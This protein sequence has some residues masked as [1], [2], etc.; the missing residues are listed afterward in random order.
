MI[1]IDEMAFAGI[2]LITTLTMATSVLF[3]IFIVRLLQTR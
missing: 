1:S 3:F 2:D